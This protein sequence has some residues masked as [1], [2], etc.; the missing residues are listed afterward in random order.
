MRKF[1]SALLVF[2]L[3]TSVAIP[4]TA[5]EA[6]QV[7]YELHDLCLC[8]AHED[9]GKIPYLTFGIG[10]EGR[11]IDDV[12][13]KWKIFV[14]AGFATKEFT[15][16]PRTD[17]GKL[18]TLLDFVDNVNDCKK[19]SEPVPVEIMVALATGTGGSAELIKGALTD[20]A[21]SEI[22]GASG[23]TASAEIIHRSVIHFNNA[24]NAQ[25]NAEK[26]FKVL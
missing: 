10:Y 11:V 2:L 3:L 26:L 5:A 12:K 25:K 1:I 14:H 18:V 22:L 8:G 6:P 16:T 13:D 21:L 20:D 17:L 24:K 4:A 15:I 23:I 7:Y 19:E 9:L